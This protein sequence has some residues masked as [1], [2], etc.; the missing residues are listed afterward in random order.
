MI[1]LFYPKPNILFY[2]D[3]DFADLEMEAEPDDMFKQYFSDM[4]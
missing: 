4:L 2:S 3:T 1:N